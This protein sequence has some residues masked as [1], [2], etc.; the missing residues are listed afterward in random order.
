MKEGVSR[1]K[2]EDTSISM[3]MLFFLHMTSNSGRQECFRMFPT[4]LK[5]M[6]SHSFTYNINEHVYMALEI[7][8][9]KKKEIQPSVSHIFI[10]W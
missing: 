1:R 5:Y 7:S 9:K 8:L 3:S 4:I 6:L 10:N 2:G